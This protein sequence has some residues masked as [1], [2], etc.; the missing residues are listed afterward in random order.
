M[1]V[2]NNEIVVMNKTRALSDT[3]D[4]YPGHVR[5]W[6]ALDNKQQSVLIKSGKTTRKGKVCG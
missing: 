6:D 1:D 4:E 3:V 5:D 2:P